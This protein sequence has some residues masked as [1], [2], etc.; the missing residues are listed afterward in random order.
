MIA[1]GRTNAEIADELYVSTKTIANTVSLIY[2]KLQVHD[3]AA[4]VVR[5]RNAGLGN[6]APD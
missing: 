3:R 5:A 1:S 4:A 2:D 6:P